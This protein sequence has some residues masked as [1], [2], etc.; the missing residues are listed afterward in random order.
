MDTRLTASRRR[1]FL[2]AVLCV[3]AAGSLASCGDDDD[4]DAETVQLV[5][6]TITGVLGSSGENAEFVFPRVTDNLIETLL[7]STREECEAAPVECIGEPAAIMGVSDTEIDGDSASAL[8][9]TDFGRFR[10]GLIREEGSWKIDSVQ[11]ASDEVPDGA[12]LVDLS[13]VE[14]G[15]RLDRDAIKA[16]EPFA[17]RVTNDGKQVHE[18]VVVGIPEGS[19]LEE[20]VE[21]VGEEELPPVAFKVFITPGQELDMAFEDDLPPGNYA[22]V[23]F[24]PDTSDPEFTAHIEKGMVAEF[25][26]P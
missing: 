3:F 13:L 21:I 25:T 14:F 1:W 12:N 22:L 20:A 8:A 2:A 26:R 16:G 6:S 23:C 7:F 15:F 4:N 18:V 19:T 11:A 5:E 17:F 10:V 9:D 24:F